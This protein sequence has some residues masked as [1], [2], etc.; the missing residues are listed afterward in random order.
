MVKVPPYRFEQCLS[1]FTMLLVE[2]YCEAAL[3]RYLP[4]HAFGSS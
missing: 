3:F 4:N 2:G 1:A